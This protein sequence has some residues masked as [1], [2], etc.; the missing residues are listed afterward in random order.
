MPTSNPLSCLRI[1]ST[2]LPVILTLCTWM[3]LP[4]H[5]QEPS[6]PNTQVKAPE[7]WVG[8][9]VE[10][11]V[12]LG[13]LI[14]KP[15][16]QPAP[17]PGTQP[18]Q[19]SSAQVQ[20]MAAAAKLADLPSE[21]TAAQSSLLSIAAGQRLS[22]ALGA[23]LKAQAIEMS[24]EAQGSLP[25]RMRDVQMDSPWQASQADVKAT[26]EEILPPFGLMAQIQQLGSSERIATV[27]VRN[28]ISAR[29]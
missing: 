15:V 5:A 24:W 28:Q 10:R 1:S 27:V 3:S 22:V 25:A 21:S 6:P 29:P 11:D 12:G 20:S 13:Q 14:A 8:D 16:V 18:V 17:T 19:S 2:A 4:V 9:A 26:L 7:P 23:W